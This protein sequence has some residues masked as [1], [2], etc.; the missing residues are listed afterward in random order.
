MESR[1]STA[2]YEKEKK[3]GIQHILRDYIFIFVRL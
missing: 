2:D 1:S 3:Q